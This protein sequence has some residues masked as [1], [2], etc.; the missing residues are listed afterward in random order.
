MKNK[1]F[2][3]FLD[4]KQ[5]HSDYRLDDQEMDAIFNKSFE[6]KA[7]QLILANVV[8]TISLK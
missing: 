7:W 2:S 8:S 6:I 3:Q 5:N 1:D 4:S